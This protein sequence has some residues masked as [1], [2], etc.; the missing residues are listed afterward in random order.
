MILRQFKIVIMTK[1]DNVPAGAVTGLMATLDE[2]KLSDKLRHY[3]EERIETREL[4]DEHCTV[5]L[6]Y[7]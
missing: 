4:L 5:A 6:T 1:D 7:R 3:V 2:L